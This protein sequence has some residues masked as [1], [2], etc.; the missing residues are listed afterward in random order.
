MFKDLYRLIRIGSITLEDIKS[1]AV[2]AG[3]QA[4]IDKEVN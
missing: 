2:R 1:P 4:L 3:V